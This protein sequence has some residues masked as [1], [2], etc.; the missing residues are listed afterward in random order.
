[1]WGI[2]VG[3]EYILES[4][5]ELFSLPEY[6]LEAALVEEGVVSKK[7]LKNRPRAI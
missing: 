4:E 6:F 2:Y 1:M 5:L 3:L 7:S